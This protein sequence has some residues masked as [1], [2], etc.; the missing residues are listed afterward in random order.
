VVFF[1]SKRFD[2]TGFQRESY[3]GHVWVCLVCSSK[4]M[5]ALK[6]GASVVMTPPAN[7]ANWVERLWS[8]ES[9]SPRDKTRLAIATSACPARLPDSEGILPVIFFIFP[10][11]THVYVITNFNGRMIYYLASFTFI[12]VLT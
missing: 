11:T 3:G 1:F 8:S 12:G 5:G 7:L 10:V 4:A 2:L 9:E 6:H